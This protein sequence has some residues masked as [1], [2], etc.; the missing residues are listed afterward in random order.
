MPKK[1]TRKVPKIR[2]RNYYKEKPD[3]LM[4]L[5]RRLDVN[6]SGSLT[7]EELEPLAKKMRMRAESLKRAMDSDKNNKVNFPEFKRY[8]M[9]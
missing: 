9:R 6:D 3:D 8:M 7:T 1:P 4:A 5:F 2:S